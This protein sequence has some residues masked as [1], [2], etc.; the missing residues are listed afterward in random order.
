MGILLTAD[1]LLHFQRCNRRAFL[2]L[3]GDGSQLEPPGDYL[4]K[5]LRDSN[6]H[7]RKVLAERSGDRPHY[8]AGDWLA[9]DDATR[10]LMYQGV[11]CIQ[12]GILMIPHSAP[13]AEDVMLVSCPDLLVKKPGQS[14]FGDW[15]Y[16]PIAIKLG[17]RPKLEY[18]VAATF[19]AYVIS[20]VQNMPTE[21]AWLILREKGMYR[22][23]VVSVMPQ[24]QEIL[25]NCVHVLTTAQEPE[26]FIS[27]NRCSLC[28]WFN[29]C[30]SIAQAQQ[31]LSLISGVTPSRYAVLQTLNLTTLE[32]LANTS[33]VVLEPLA[34]FGKDA[35]EKLVLQAQASLTKTAMRRSSMS[36]NLDQEI[37]SR[38]VEIYFDIEADPDMTLD[39]LLGVMVVDYE[40]K[41]DRFYSFLAETP[42]E[43][44]QVWH[45]FLNLMAQYPNAP[46]FHF[47]P[48]ETHTIKRLAALYHTPYA[49]IQSVLSRC[50]D[51][52][53]RVTRLVVLPVESYALK[54]IARWLGFEWRDAN[55]TGAQA[56]CWY[57]QW[58][59][60]Q[61]RAYLD[62][63]VTY[64]EDDCRAMYHLKNWLIR[65]FTAPGEHSIHRLDK[66]S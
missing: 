2:D 21:Q 6:S 27:R 49:T 13:Y 9:G 10:Q 36:L 50:I 43:E 47:C 12:Q 55:A 33:P 8:T 51:L 37:P 4:L 45:Q 57:T 31:H 18:Q 40:A 65:F 24:M 58:L 46:I 60:T 35:A 61:D 11:E 23:D 29:H 66:P 7:R 63:I 39:Y 26:V 48:Y 28:P 41:D 52:H 14:Q 53:E 3:Y 22:V 5:L 34:G 64:N 54:H 42:E 25:A 56:V 16:V 1:L 30:Y 17:K 15:C 44:Q 62:A 59:E 19:D 20:M 38:R 32:A